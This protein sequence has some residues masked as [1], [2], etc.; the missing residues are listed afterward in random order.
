MKKVF[1]LFLFVFF[2]TSCD[3]I[4]KQ[5]EDENTIQN[6]TPE[7]GIAKEKDEN[8]CVVEAG[9]KWSKIY[10]NCKRVIEEGYRLNPIDSLDNLEASKSAYVLIDESKLKAEVFLPN[11]SESIY[12]ERKNDALDFIHKSYKLSLKSGYLLFLN[13]I[14]IYKA[15]KT[16]DKP[17]VGSDEIE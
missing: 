16:V 3:Y 8:G 13:D 5:T 4:L 15:A 11:A 12:F 2:A 10:K 17:V 6:K 14:A 7:L 1:C 9:Y